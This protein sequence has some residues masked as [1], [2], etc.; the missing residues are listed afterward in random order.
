MG[1]STSSSGPRSGVPFDPPWLDQLESFHSGTE[2][3]ESSESNN[4]SSTNKPTR[5]APSR[6]FS[7][8][9]R[10]LGIFAR[11]GNQDAFQ[12]A[13]GHY[14]RTGMGGAKNTANRMRVSTKSAAGLISFLQAARDGSDPGVNQ[15]VSSLAAKNPNAQD[16]IN[17]IIQQITSS[18]GS[19]DEES[20]R[21][22]MDQALAKLLEVQPNVDLLRMS[23]E[24]IWTVVELFL[25]YEAYNRIYNDIGQLFESSKLNPKIV[26]SRVNE[27]R[28]YLK[29]EISVQIRSLRVINAN[30]SSK[31]L[32][33]LMQEALKN[34]FLVYEGVL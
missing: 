32:E 18:G 22:S 1:T 13:V 17:E 30:P 16:V 5:L 6:R 3:A 14:S 31:Q 29:S 9:R 8:A 25:G 15:W 7:N 19:R 34:T 20:C 33:S 24:D 28:D 4:D 11:T 27:M 12:K 23:D 26:V 2:E 21:D 10:E